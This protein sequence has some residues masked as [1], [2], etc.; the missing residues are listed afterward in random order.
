MK[1]G[2]FSRKRV[3]QGLGIFLFGLF[4]GIATQSSSYGQNSTLPKAPY[5]LSQEVKQWEREGKEFTF[6]DVRAPE[7]FSPGHLPGAVNIPYSEMEKRVNEFKQDHTYVF[8][9]IYSSWRAP[10]AANVLADL[11]FKKVYIL[12]G[13]VNAWNAGGQV[14]YASAKDVKARIAPYPSGLAKILKHP[15][16]QQYQEKVQLTKEELASFNGQN[17]RPAYV[18]VKGIVYDVT[19]SRLWRGGVHD[20]GHGKV[21]AGQDLTELLVNQAPHGV[22]NLEK[23]PVV[24]SLVE[25]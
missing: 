15:P 1:S 12:E 13:G 10:Y 5:V 4:L 25:K 3:I 17:G 7:E 11:G 18:A 16:D 2:I 19:Q 9:C 23:F 6:V 22:E 8:Y 24:G 20:P 21:L 14:L